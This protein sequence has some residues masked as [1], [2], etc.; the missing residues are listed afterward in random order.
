MHPRLAIN[1]TNIITTRTEWSTLG[2]LKRVKGQ[3]VENFLTINRSV[4]R[5]MERMEHKY[6]G[7]IYILNRTVNITIFV[8]LVSSPS[9]EKGKTECRICRFSALL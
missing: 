6:Y 9:S 3:G 4:V 2:P 1:S 8:S 7:F 5:Y